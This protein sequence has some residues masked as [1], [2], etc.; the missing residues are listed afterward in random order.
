M[1]GGGGG[2]G[3]EKGDNSSCW[4]YLSFEKAFSLNEAIRSQ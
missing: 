2:K 1:G 3:G 4:F